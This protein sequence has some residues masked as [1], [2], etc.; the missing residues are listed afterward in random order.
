MI[1]T[2]RSSARSSANP[3]SRGELSGAFDK[4]ADRT[5]WKLP[6][7]ATVDL[8]ER[9]LAMVQEAVI[10]FTG[11]VPKFEARIGAAL[12]LSRACRRLLPHHR[13]LTMT[14]KCTL[15]GGE[16]GT[17]SPNGAHYLCEAGAARGQP[18]P[19]QS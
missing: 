17:L 19:W 4:V 5:N 15:C 3:F 10:F 2:T 18:T 11:S 6:V 9:E 16:A 1:T 13:S 8:D 14:M 7:L 12:P